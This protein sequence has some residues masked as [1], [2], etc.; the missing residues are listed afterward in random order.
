VVTEVIV[1]TLSVV[2]E[3]IVVT[4]SVVT[5]VIVEARRICVSFDQR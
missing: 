4:L 1:V 3:V 5:E 2:T